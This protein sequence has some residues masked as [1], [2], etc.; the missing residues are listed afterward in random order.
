MENYGNRWEKQKPY[1]TFT[2][3][4]AEDSESRATDRFCGSGGENLAKSTAKMLGSWAQ[5]LKMIIHLKT[6]SLML[7]NEEEEEGIDE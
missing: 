3:F 5:G 1:F 7:C 6:R 4:G 2:Y